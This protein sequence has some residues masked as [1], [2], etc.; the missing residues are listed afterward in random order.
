MKKTNQHLIKG[1]I[2]F[3]NKK[4]LNIFLILVF[5][6][7]N[8]P[9]INADDNK[10]ITMQQASVK[11]TFPQDSIINNI[12]FSTEII[13]EKKL[14]YDQ[15]TLKD[16]YLYGK[17]KRKF[18]WE[19]IKEK[20]AFV[21][22]IQRKQNSWGILQ[23]YKNRNG[24]APL[25]K[26]YKK[27]AYNNIAD[28]YGVERYQGIPLYLP[29]DTLSVE[30]YGLD[31]SLVKIVNNND[32]LS[33]FIDVKTL[34][35]RGDWNV[36]EKFVKILPD[37]TKFKHVIVVDVKNQNIATL[38]KE[39]SKWLI[40]SMNPATTGKHNPP[41]MQETPLGIFVIQEKKSKMFY[42][43]DGTSEIAGFAPNASRFCNGGYIH[44]VPLVYPNETPA[45]FS[46]TLGTVPRSHM[47]VRNATS[48]AKY[49][50]GTFPTN[51]TLIFVID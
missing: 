42:L 26:E 32:T 41:H 31:G 18:Q 34:Y 6:C 20:L 9:N 11:K 1:K 8:I 15:H 35:N 12:P 16:E 28:T 2:V 4:L 33:K 45:E 43:K 38:E 44:G 24:T 19:K 23:N 36:P 25:V 46:W 30:R 51:S 48:H 13:L 49:I 27:D 22:S 37:T 10:T 3:C 14:I 7:S 40:R 29:H 47:C 5:I 39:G 21:D 17:I 50:Y